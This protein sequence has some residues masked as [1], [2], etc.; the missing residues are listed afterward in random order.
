MG[1]SA[2]Q[3]MSE[4]F[5]VDFKLPGPSVA[6]KSAGVIFPAGNHM[7]PRTRGTSDLATRR[8]EALKDLVEGRRTVRVDESNVGH[9]VHA[10]AVPH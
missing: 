9:I 3:S 1:P 4:R 5:R 7:R 6:C 2:R 8:R 10:I